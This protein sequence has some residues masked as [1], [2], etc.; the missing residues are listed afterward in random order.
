MKVCVS[1]NVIYGVNKS[2]WP[3]C[4]NVFWAA[5][6]GDFFSVLR[7][8][9]ENLVKIWISIFYTFVDIHYGS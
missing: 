1:K 3:F 7:D 2:S 9:G 5:S 6:T 8:R 4:Y